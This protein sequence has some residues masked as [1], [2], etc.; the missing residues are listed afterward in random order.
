MVHP[1][2]LGT[3]ITPLL[4]FLFCAFIGLQAYRGS[5]HRRK[6]AAKHIINTVWLYRLPIPVRR[7]RVFY[8]FKLFLLSFAAHKGKGGGVST[9]CHTIPCICKNYFETFLFVSYEP[10]RIGFIV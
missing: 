9:L 7:M 5:S 1:F 8:L 2:F 4:A 3:T 10:S 6:G